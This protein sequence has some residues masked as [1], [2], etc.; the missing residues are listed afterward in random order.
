MPQNTNNPD[1]VLKL[2]FSDAE[3]IGLTQQNTLR[4]V[5]GILGMVLP[6]L[7]YVFVWIDTGYSSPMHSISHYYFTRAASIFCVIVSLM[8]IFMIIYKGKEPIDFYLAC[9]AG[10]FAILLVLF[11]TDN[12]STI[13]CDAEKTYAVTVLKNNHFR[14]LLHYIASAIFLLCLAAMSLFVFTKSN[15]PPRNRTNH[16]IV[17][18]RL[19]RICGVIMIA[20]LLIAF[21]GGFMGWIPEAVYERNNITF[22]METISV[23]AFGLS[24]LVKGGA[25]LKDKN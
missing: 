18:N 2:N 13:C 21:A 8:A 22:W 3:T 14:I 15:Q 1:A 25:I 17:R 19:Y 20:A 6:L 10:I 4:K 11:P 23:E 16:K 7:L 9:A 5:V 12:I 24:W